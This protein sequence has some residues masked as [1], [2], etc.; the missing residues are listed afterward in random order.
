MKGETSGNWRPAGAARTCGAVEL[1]SGLH[2]S[3]AERKEVEAEEEEEEEGKLQEAAAGFE[4]RRSRSSPTE[5]ISPE[6]TDPPY[7]V[8]SI[9]SKFIC[10][11]ICKFPHTKVRGST[12]WPHDLVF[13]CMHA[14]N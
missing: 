14:Q 12:Y 7:A 10:I 3:E 9:S 6:W 11:L 4:G 2:E 13:R 8:G 1:I 5:L